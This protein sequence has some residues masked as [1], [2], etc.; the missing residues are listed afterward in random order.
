M[1]QKTPSNTIT[2]A[3]GRS[4]FSLAQ[5]MGETRRENMVYLTKYRLGGMEECRIELD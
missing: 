2:D 4:C 3:K 5:V 1:R